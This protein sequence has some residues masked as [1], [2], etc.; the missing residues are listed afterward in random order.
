MTIEKNSDYSK[1]TYTDKVPEMLIEKAHSDLY[2]KPTQVAIARYFRVSYDT[3]SLWKKMHPEFVAAIAKANEVVNDNAESTLLKR[4]H[5]YEFTEEKEEVTGDG[6]KRTT[7][8]KHMPA[9][10]ALLKYF[11][12]NRRSK[13]WSDRQEIHQTGTTTTVIVQESDA[14]LL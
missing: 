13:D 11:L 14:Q 2:F 3:I 6:I 1:M 12:N 4:V 10:P 7:M 9:D 5:G 8:K